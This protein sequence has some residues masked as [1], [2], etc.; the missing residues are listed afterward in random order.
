MGI[1]IWTGAATGDYSSAGNW[2]DG[3]APAM[4][5]ILVIENATATANTVAI[6]ADEIWLNSV[7]HAQVGISLI[8]TTLGAGSEL[9]STAVTGPVTVELHNTPMEGTVFAAYGSTIMTV[10]SGS[11]ALNYGWIAVA[12]GAGGYASD[13]L[14]ASGSFANVGVIE[15]GVNGTFSMAFGELGAQSIINVGILQADAGGTMLLNGQSAGST[16]IN[17]NRINAAG[18]TVAI[19]SD[20]Q[21]TDGAYTA[22]T[23]DGSLVLTGSTKGGTIDIQSGMLSFA[24]AP[25]FAPGPTAA[26]ELQSSIEFSGLSGSINFGVTSIS[27]FFNPQTSVLTIDVPWK[28][29]E[30]Q[31]AHLHLTGPTYFPRDFTTQGG[32]LIYHAPTNS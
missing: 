16:I 26:A 32:V 4:G 24:P 20:L 17:G 15:A 10:D 8:N 5:D 23:N 18:G 3:Q 9:I 29:G 21:Q 2:S 6:V 1:K 31:I 27:D 7:D 22:V 30:A 19:N 25:Q 12:S 11:T 14:I 13:T 28:G